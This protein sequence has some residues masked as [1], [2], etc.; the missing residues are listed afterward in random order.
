MFENVIQYVHAILF[1]KI[2]FE[3]T[4]HIWDKWRCKGSDVIC[5]AM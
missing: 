3:L 5:I 1:H 2:Q 4:R